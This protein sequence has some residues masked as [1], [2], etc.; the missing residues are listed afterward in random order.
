M[1]E[2]RKRDLRAEATR[3]HQAF[4]G[5]RIRRLDLDYFIQLE[6]LAK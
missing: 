6:T 5:F 1:R 3:L 4:A 2:Q